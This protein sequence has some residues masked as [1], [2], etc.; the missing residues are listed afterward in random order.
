MD[1]ISSLAVAMLLETELTRDQDRPGAPWPLLSAASV[2][3]GVRAP[4]NPLA[5]S[6]GRTTPK[7]EMART[8][9]SGR[10]TVGREGPRTQQRKEERLEKHYGGRGA[11][12]IRDGNRNGGGTRVWQIPWTEGLEFPAMAPE[13]VGCCGP[14]REQK[15]PCRH[16]WG[17]GIGWSGGVSFLQRPH[18]PQLSHPAQQCR[19]GTPGLG[20]PPEPPS[21]RAARSPW[22][23]ENNGG[24]AGRPARC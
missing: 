8:A 24:I 22:T 18:A 7:G 15:G 13:D 10:G 19:T 3:L 16:C 2:G 5:S 6:L 21:P 20:L 12:P 9:E 17:E 1:S 14:P 23:L 11:A 4:A